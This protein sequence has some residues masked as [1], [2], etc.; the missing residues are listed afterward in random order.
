MKNKQNR[1]AHLVPDKFDP[2]TLCGARADRSID[3]EDVKHVTCKRCKK[4]LYVP[5]SQRWGAK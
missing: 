1:K 3:A 2:Q 4:M 5:P